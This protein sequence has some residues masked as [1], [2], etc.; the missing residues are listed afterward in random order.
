MNPVLFY[1]V[2]TI[3]MPQ[4]QPDITYRHSEPSYEQCLSDAK[5]F[6][7]HQLPDDIKNPAGLIATCEVHGFAPHE[8]S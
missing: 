2:L 7:S 6:L 3:V 4:G 8:K 1:I 5:E